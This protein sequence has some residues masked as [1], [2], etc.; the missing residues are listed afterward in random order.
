M[1]LVFMIS[2]V[3]KYEMEIRSVHEEHGY[4]SSM[5]GMEKYGGA[6]F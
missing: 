3:Q 4:C 1:N 5:G 6:L 2:N